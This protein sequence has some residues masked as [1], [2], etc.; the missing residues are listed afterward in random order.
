MVKSMDKSNLDTFKDSVR[1]EKHLG[2]IDRQAQLFLMRC[3]I[4]V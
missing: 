1:E 4:N 3:K 2:A